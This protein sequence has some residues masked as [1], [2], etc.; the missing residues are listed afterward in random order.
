MKAWIVFC[1]DEYCGLFHADTEGQAKLR[2]M[3]CYGGDDYLQYRARR[4]PGLDGKPITY[5]NAKDAGFEYSD[6]DSSRL[7]SELEFINDCQCHIC[8]PRISHRSVS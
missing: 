7:L 2:M 4:L 6:G 3:Y 8:V 5:Q 1:G